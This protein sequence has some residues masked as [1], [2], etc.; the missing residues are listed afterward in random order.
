MQPADLPQATEARSI[1]AK[2][3]AAFALS[4]WIA[5]L[6]GPTPFSRT[7]I[8]LFGWGLVYGWIAI[9]AGP[10]AVLANF[11]APTACVLILRGR[12]PRWSLVTSLALPASSP[13]FWSTLAELGFDTWGEVLWVASL[14][15]LVA[16][17]LVMRWRRTFR[18]GGEL[19]D[20]DVTPDTP[21]PD[22]KEPQ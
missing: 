16:A 7:G 13:V 3:L 5:S 15:L 8:E 14:G 11:T 6:F 22:E 9:T 20:T 18:R 12:K 17:T 1:T 19:A 21:A 10:W 2:I 4:L